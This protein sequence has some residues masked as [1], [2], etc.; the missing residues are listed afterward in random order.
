MMVGSDLCPFIDPD[1]NESTEIC[2]HDTHELEDLKEFDLYCSCLRSKGTLYLLKGHTGTSECCSSYCPECGLRDCFGCQCVVDYGDPRDDDGVDWGFSEPGGR[3]A[4][5][6]A[7]H[8]RCVEHGCH[9]KVKPE[10][11]FCPECGGRQNPRKHQCPSCGR[12]GVLT[13]ADVEHHYVCDPCADAAER[14]IDPP[15]YWD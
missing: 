15:D 3:S 4:L 1:L 12:K 6:A 10:W 2:G 11:S 8:D 9:A 13:D 5:R 7:T 14:G